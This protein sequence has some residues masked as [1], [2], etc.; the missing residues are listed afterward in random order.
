MMSLA[1]VPCMSR[2]MHSINPPLL[3]SSADLPAMDTTAVFL[4]W[5]A[6]RQGSGLQGEAGPTKEERLQNP[7]HR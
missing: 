2:G 1:V 6:S 5:E 7:S 3:C 4:L